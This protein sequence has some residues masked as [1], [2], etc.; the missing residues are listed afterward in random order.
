MSFFVRVKLGDEK[1]IIEIA[2]NDLN[3]NV[4]A[5]KGKTKFLYSYEYYYY[6]YY[7]SSAKI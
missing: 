4:F 3:V 7:Y 5:K 6:R 2:E 1:E